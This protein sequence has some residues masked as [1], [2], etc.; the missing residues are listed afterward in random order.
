MKDGVNA[1]G[2]I[3]KS[4]IA[5]KWCEQDA[6]LER[7][8]ALFRERSEDIQ[9]KTRIKVCEVNSLYFD[10]VRIQQVLLQAL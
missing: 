6:E 1:I 4:R 10:I 8:F 7:L 5:G 3:L 2:C 9:T